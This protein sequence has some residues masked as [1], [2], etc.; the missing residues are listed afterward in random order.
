MFMQIGFSFFFVGLAFLPAAA[1]TA[2]LSISEFA[3]II[4]LRAYVCMTV[5]ACVWLLLR[6]YSAPK[7]HAEFHIEP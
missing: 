4:Y 7:F 5:R 3:I 2:T 6:G 1:S